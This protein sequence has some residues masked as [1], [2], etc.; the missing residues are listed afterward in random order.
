MPSEGE[1]KFNFIFLFSIMKILRQCFNI[2][3]KTEYL[4]R[5]SY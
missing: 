4:L 5:L 3:N 1:K 2:G